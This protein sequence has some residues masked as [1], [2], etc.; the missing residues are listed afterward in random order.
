[1]AG[2][3]IQCRSNCQNGKTTCLHGF[4]HGH[5]TGTDA[6]GNPITCPG[7]DTCGTC[8]GSGFETL[9]E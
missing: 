2:N 4:L 1:M 6:E 8:N 7:G 3:P 5:Q 9:D